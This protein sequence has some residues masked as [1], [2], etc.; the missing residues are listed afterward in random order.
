MINP[1]NLPADV[2]DYP[3]EPENKEILLSL[4]PEHARG[5][6]LDVEHIFEVVTA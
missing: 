4:L 3:L 1:D 6:I 5:I 2:V